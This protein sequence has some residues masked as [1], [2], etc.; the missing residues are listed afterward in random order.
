[1]KVVILTNVVEAKIAKKVRSL[2]ILDVLT[3]AQFTPTEVV[4]KIRQ[5]I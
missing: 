3:K 1:M 5:L 2:G 4:N